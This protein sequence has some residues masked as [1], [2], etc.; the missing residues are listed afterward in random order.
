MPE[1]THPLTRYESLHWPCL[2]HA[3][4]KVMSKSD[5]GAV[6][7]TTD[8]EEVTQPSVVAET[9][10]A[11]DADITSGRSH[12]VQPAAGEEGPPCLCS[13]L[14]LQTL[15]DPPSDP[16]SAPAP[17]PS[18]RRRR[19]PGNVCTGSCSGKKS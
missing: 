14:H 19:E 2:Q 1:V 13:Y 7:A 6:S 4:L 15:T 18:P 5:A 17:P 11:A 10:P 3:R 8:P 12:C 9:A 16:K